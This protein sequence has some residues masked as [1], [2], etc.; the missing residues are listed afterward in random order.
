MYVQGYLLG[1]I[2]GADCKQFPFLYVMYL[3]R[4]HSSH[5]REMYENEE[6]QTTVYV[7][8]QNRNGTK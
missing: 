8:T 4:Q 2:D 7:K 1:N 5:Q 3:V 6:Y